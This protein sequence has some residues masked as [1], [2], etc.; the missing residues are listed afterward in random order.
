MY[1]VKPFKLAFSFIV[2]GGAGEVSGWVLREWVDM[3][4]DRDLCCFL[5][6][7]PSVRFIHNMYPDCTYLV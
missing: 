4:A 3:V 1:D 6:S 5:G 7:P 2:R